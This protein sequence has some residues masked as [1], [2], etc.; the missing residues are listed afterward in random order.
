[1]AASGKDPDKDPD[2]ERVINSIEKIQ[3]D[4]S[5]EKIERKTIA[6]IEQ[7]KKDFKREQLA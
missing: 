7:K 1:M 3:L 4:E 6:Q 5:I 2:I